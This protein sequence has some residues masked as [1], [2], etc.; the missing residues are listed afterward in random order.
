MRGGGLND[1]ATELSSVREEN[2]TGKAN[3]ETSLRTI[4]QDVGNLT[5]HRRVGESKRRNLADQLELLNK[6]IQEMKPEV[7]PKKENLRMWRK[8]K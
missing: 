1:S 6:A 8:W 5:D 3:L 7:G 4:L 2:A